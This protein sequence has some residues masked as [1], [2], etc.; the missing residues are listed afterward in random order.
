MAV[1]TGNAL[2]VHLALDERAPVVHLAAHLTVVP[3][4]VIVESRKTMGRVRRLAMHVGVGQAACARVA[5]GAG[6]DLT[7]RCSRCAAFCVAGLGYRRPRNALAFIEGDREA[8]VR[9]ELLPLAVLLRP[10]DV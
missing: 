1:R 5:T 4:Q 6:I 2:C 9:I 3:V 7:R 8:F 10:G